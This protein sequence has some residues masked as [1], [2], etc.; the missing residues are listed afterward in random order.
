MAGTDEGRRSVV[1][2]AFAGG[3]ACGLGIAAVGLAAAAPSKT[4]MPRHDAKAARANLLAIQGVAFDRGTDLGLPVATRDGKLDFE[5]PAGLR[6]RGVVVLRI[7]KALCRHMGDLAGRTLGP[8]S[9]NGRPLVGNRPP[10]CFDDPVTAAGTRA[11][12]N[13]VVSSLR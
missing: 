7:T 13:L 9:V 10:T 8:V 11:P 2:W 4:W 1:R 3:V 12:G 6:K 5:G